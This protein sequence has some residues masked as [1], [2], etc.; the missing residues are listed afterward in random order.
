MPECPGDRCQVRM[1]CEII[2]SGIQPVQNL[3]VLQNVAKLVQSQHNNTLPD[4]QLNKYKV[5]WAK[6]AIEKGFKSLE[7]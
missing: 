2:N 7:S 3:S 6:E 1:I 5:E 4:E